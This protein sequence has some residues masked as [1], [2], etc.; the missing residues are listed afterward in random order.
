[1]LLL[2]GRLGSSTELAGDLPVDLVHL[3]DVVWQPPSGLARVDLLLLAL[4]RHGNLEPPAGLRSLLRGDLHLATLEQLLQLG[5]EGVLA[6]L[7]VHLVRSVTAVHDLY[8]D[9]IR[10]GSGV[11]SDGVARC[12][13][14]VL[15]HWSN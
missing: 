12:R 11:V 4:V 1:M 8:L 9:R 13:I 3:E 7:A 6:L 5:L 14:R 10:S 2:P 15:V